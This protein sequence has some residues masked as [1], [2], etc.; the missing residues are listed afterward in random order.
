MGNYM[1]SF[2]SIGLTY[3]KPASSEFNSSQCTNILI[4]LEL[5]NLI[6]YFLTTHGSIK[7]IKYSEDID[8]KSWKE[9]NNPDISTIEQYYEAISSGFY[10]EITIVSDILKI[11]NLDCILRVEKQ[12]NFFG[13]LL[14][15]KEEDLLKSKSYPDEDIEIITGKLIELMIKFYS[16]TKYDY[17]FCDQEA[18]FNYSP[19]TFRKLKENVY[20]VVVTP[21]CDG[22]AFDITKSNWNIDGHTEREIQ[23]SKREI[24]RV[25]N[26]KKKRDP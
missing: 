1:G 17:A 26:C 4:R 10:G 6:G 9:I 25:G 2:I 19:E 21:N 14:D 3:S 11:G 18:E 13:F 12:D 20:S 16:Y 23:G 8:G 24:F 5:Q 15:F 7:K 22:S